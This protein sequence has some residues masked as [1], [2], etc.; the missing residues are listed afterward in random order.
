MEWNMMGNSDVVAPQLWVQGT[1]PAEVHQHGRMLK[2]STHPSVY[3]QCLQHTSTPFYLQ[4]TLVVASVYTQCL[5]NTCVR[6]QAHPSI[7]KALC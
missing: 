7:S 3:T 5:Y 4:G 6:A 2:D 1:C